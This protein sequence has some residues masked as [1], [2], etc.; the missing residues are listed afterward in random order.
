[1]TPSAQP[2][3]TF[4]WLIALAAA[5]WLAAAAFAGYKYAKSTAMETRTDADGKERSVSVV[6]DDYRG[7]HLAAAT[8]ALVAAITCGVVAA[9]ARMVPPDPA[10][11]ATRRAS[12]DIL[13]A[14]TVSGAALL[15]IGT[16][17]LAQD[18]GTLND[19]LSLGRSG[20]AWKPVAA[21]LAM[22]AG[23][24]IAFAV[25]IPARSEERN[26]ETIRRLVYGTNAAVSGLLLLIGLIVL[27]VMVAVKLPSK[28]DTT[29]SGF[30]TL[31]ESTQNYIRNLD[32]KF[33]VYPLLRSRGREVDDMRWMLE[34]CQELNPSRFVVR[35]FGQ[36]I[37]DS[38]IRALRARF[39]QVDIEEEGLLIA[40]GDDESRY[41]FLLARD[42]IKFERGREPG[43]GTQLF[44]GESRLMR[45]ML[46]LGDDK[47]KPVVYFTQ[48]HGEL[49]LSPRPDDANPVRAAIRL[50]GFLEEA[51]YVVKPLP[52]DPREP[53]L[54]ADAEMIVV[55]DPQQGIRAELAELLKAFVLEPR[56]GAKPGKLILISG[57]AAGLGGNAVQPTGLESLLEETGLK[58]Q[59]YYLINEPG[60]LSPLMS[61]A[62]TTLSA[63][64]ARLPMAMM[65]QETA[66]GLPL[67]RPLAP[68]N[69]NPEFQ[70]MPLLLT[71]GENRF[72]WL[73]AK[74]PE[75][76]EAEFR[77]MMQSTPQAEALRRSKD[78]TSS[79]RL[80]AAA[81]TASAG[82]SPVPLMVVF[83]FSHAFSDAAAR[84]SSEA[85]R[86]WQMISTSL[87][88]LRDRP[89][90]DVAH[91]TY[92]T[93]VPSAAMD[94]TR[95][96]LLPLGL[97]VLA[98]A[99]M[100]CGIWVIRRS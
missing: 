14:G 44:V 85:A 24:G 53:K 71:Y 9:R 70:V 98:L 58:L 97:V 38:E 64:R 69:P 5:G 33:T 83:G 81:V 95:L 90:V 3:R 20:G 55:A 66:L 74:L 96:V 6:V 12:I 37:P 78:L 75:N 67:C 45:E 82:D 21:M 41:S 60:Q 65:L 30:Y 61:I 8:A 31:A 36:A 84:N 89:F 56:P 42:M 13:I 15:L 47:T 92:G 7:C 27:N 25:C 11:S 22:V 4:T 35:N 26:D 16:R 76:P 93:Y 46:F 49:S 18:F 17:F 63:I 68:G 43:S 88:W 77:A 40:A 100:G 99:A 54:P 48:G 79:P 10:Q 73:D 34:A 50:R 28:L 57:P 19:W 80:L 1:M 2:P 94:E 51:N 59:Q 23:A 86:N 91:K 29:E 62:T 72:T 32:Q 87:D 52:F 39:K